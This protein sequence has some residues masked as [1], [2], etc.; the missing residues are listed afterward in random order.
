MA[1]QDDKVKKVSLEIS[2]MVTLVTKVELDSQGNRAYQD[3]LVAQEMMD[4]QDCL[5]EEGNQASQEI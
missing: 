4:Y 2:G 1:F 3:Y 5:V